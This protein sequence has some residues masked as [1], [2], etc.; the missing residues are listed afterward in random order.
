MVS[1]TTRLPAQ[2][3]GAPYETLPPYVDGSALGLEKPSGILK[4]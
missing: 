4:E 3:E 1:V 2:T